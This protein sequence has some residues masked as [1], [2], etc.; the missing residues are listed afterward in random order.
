MPLPLQYNN[1][2]GTDLQVQSDYYAA[3][4][5][6]S[7]AVER[8][9]ELTWCL[10]IAS[11]PHICFSPENIQTI[12]MLLL[13]MQHEAFPVLLPSLVT[14]PRDKEVSEFRSL[15]QTVFS[16][17]KSVLYCMVAFHTNRGLQAP[18]RNR[19]C[20]CLL[21]TCEC[22]GPSWLGL[23]PFIAPNTVARIRSLAAVL[24]REDV[25]HPDK[26][27]AYCKPSHHVWPPRA[28]LLRG[29]APS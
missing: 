19:Q 21:W 3:F 25:E 29:Y 14:S 26:R 1:M 22:L 5:H 7:V 28:G 15:L 10:L 20:M 12:N 16:C 6:Q 23:Q 27:C 24:S 9:C 11:A 18:V 13:S 2:H 4:H 17:L 8:P